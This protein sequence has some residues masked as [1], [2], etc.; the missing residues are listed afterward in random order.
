MHSR[1]TPR[2]GSIIAVACK[3]LLALLL[4][5]SP[6]PSISLVFSLPPLLYLL[7]HLAL[8]GFVIKSF[9]GRDCVCTSRKKLSSIDRTSVNFC[10]TELRLLLLLFWGIS[11]LEFEFVELFEGSIMLCKS[12]ARVAQKLFRLFVESCCSAGSWGVPYICSKKKIEKRKEQE[13]EGEEVNLIP[14]GSLWE[15]RLFSIGW[16]DSVA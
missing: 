8:T 12:A 4:S 3:K 13:K 9:C 2:D 6:S 14:A 10:V 1:I 11:L 16:F 7:A 15:K 5:L